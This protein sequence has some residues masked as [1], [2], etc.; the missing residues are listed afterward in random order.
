MPLPLRR[1]AFYYCILLHVTLAFYCIL[2]LQEL[3]HAFAAIESEF[4]YGIVLLHAIYH[5][6]LRNNWGTPLRR[7]C[8]ALHSVWSLLPCCCVV[9][10]L[11]CCRA[12]SLLQL[13][14]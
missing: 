8:T 3:G 9:L 7:F 2:P 14:Y 5:N 13:L 4:Y 6:D 1:F 10:L 12:A 11:Y